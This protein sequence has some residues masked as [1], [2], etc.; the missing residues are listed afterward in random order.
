M[1]YEC[2]DDFWVPMM[3]IT[4]AASE[5]Q[6]RAHP[7]ATCE[8]PLTAQNPRIAARHSYLS[9]LGVINEAGKR[10]TLK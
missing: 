3:V 9:Q 4:S 10:K 1:K 8:V 5:T 6:L 7:L 2:N